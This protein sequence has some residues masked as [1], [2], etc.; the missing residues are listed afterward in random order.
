MGLSRYA[1]ILILCTGFVSSAR[2][3]VEH[4]IATETVEEDEIKKVVM[5]VPEDQ[6]DQTASTIGAIEGQFS[7]LPIELVVEHAA[8]LPRELNKQVELASKIA[9]TSG[10]FVVFWCDFILDDQVF[11]YLAEA[12]GQRI[13]V[14]KLEEEDAGGRAE[15]LAIILRLSISALLEGGIIGVEVEEVVKEKPIEVEATAESE[16][17]PEL[18]PESQPEPQ[19]EPDEPAREY[20]ILAT[21]LAYT[22]TSY[23]EDH[24]L[25]HGFDI[26]FDVRLSRYLIVTAG[27]TVM[28]TIETETELAGL[29]LRRHPI[30]LGLGLAFPISAMELGASLALALDYSTFDVFGKASGIKS[31]TDM[32]DILY[33]LTFVVELRIPIYDRLGL[34]IAAGGDIP[35]NSIYYQIETPPET[36][37]LIDPWPVRSRLLL[38]AYVEFL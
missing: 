4:E 38:G 21:G 30:R 36:E 33:F 16:T 19:P 28:G 13:L 31:A 14:R 12:G 35:L 22:M 3:D 5:I 15:T 26:A 32:D 24:P 23:S 7:D 11:L 8:K 6:R 9:G 1:A 18:Q 25:V 2:G 27:Y 29:R 17:K 34:I 10:A 20:H 37:V